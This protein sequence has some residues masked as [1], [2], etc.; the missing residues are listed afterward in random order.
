[1]VLSGIKYI[2]NKNDWQQE[3]TQL[4]VHLLSCIQG[5]ITVGIADLS[6]WESLNYYLSDG[7]AEKRF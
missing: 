7:H 3:F 4:C 2:E 1:M 6:Q 5:I